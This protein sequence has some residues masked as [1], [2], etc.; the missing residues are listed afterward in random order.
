VCRKC[1][2]IGYKHGC[3]AAAL[4]VDVANRGAGGLRS[5]RKN[6]TGEWMAFRVLLRSVEFFGV[7]GAEHP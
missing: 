4:C 5:S 3:S 1:R 2:L 6:A 7:S